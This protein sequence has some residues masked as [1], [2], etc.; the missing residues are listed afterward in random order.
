MLGYFLGFKE[1][2]VDVV[3]R[4]SV[5]LFRLGAQFSPCVRVH[6]KSCLGS[7]QSFFL[8]KGPLRVYLGGVRK[9]FRGCF[10]GPRD[11]VWYERVCCVRPDL[12]LVRPPFFSSDAPVVAYFPALNG[13]PKSTDRFSVL[14]LTQIFSHNHRKAR[15]PGRS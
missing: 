14:A 6:L 7:L 13:T 11:F 12:S 9:L 4:L 5:V 10:C 1:C 8:I 3:A 15:S 2:L